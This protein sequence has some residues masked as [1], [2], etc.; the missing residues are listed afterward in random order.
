MPEHFPRGNRLAAIEKNELK[1]RALE[2]V[3]LL[4]Y[5][6]D[7]KE[8]VVSSIRASDV[9][10]TC[11]ADRHLPEGTKNLYKK[12]WKVLVAKN[13]LTE[14]EANEIEKLIDYRNLVAHQTQSLT[15][16][17]GRFPSIGFGS[18][19]AQYQSDAL[20]KICRLREKVLLGMQHGG[21]VLSLS[22]RGL[23]FEAAERTYIE[24][25]KRLQGKIQKQAKLVRVEID[26]ANKTIRQLQHSG[27]LEKLQPYHP[28]HVNSNG[29]LTPLG[30]VCCIA[31]FEAGASPFV[32]AQLMRLSLRAIAARHAIW[33]NKHM[34]THA[35][36]A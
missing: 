7:L 35:T 14:D 1:R 10:H 27:L 21:F 30:V 32:V 33:Q 19:K 9:R 5:I 13:V 11:A 31:L 18:D 4:F 3:L 23:R 22:F 36:A 28:N 25:L 15:G 8:L 17:I 34:V 6:E 2:M 20:A 26:E 12:A 29:T 16:D 24:E